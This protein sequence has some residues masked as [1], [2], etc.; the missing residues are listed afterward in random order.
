METKI[1]TVQSIYP[2]VRYRNARAAIKWLTSVL[3]FQEHEVYPG[4]GE[5]I[6]HAQL[7]IAG[8]LIMLGS[9][10]G[11]A[12]DEYSE[13]PGT[14]THGV[15]IALDSAADVDA[16]YDRAKAA[17]A[18]IARE[19]CDTDYGSHEFSV[20]DPEGHRWSFGT[21]RPCIRR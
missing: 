17:G 11:D 7:A 16:C 5:S 8:N 19:I 20:S 14:V 15:Y 12:V 1:T 3:G 6:V 13:I 4:E 18:R 10:Q 9:L 21:Y 2:A